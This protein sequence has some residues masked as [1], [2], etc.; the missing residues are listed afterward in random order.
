MWYCPTLQASI[1][2][3]ALKESPFTK[4]IVIQDTD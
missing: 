2:L 1:L 3:G 4:K